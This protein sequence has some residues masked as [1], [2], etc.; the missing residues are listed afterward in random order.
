MIKPNTQEIR[1]EQDTISN[2]VREKQNT[3]WDY[4]PKDEN[5]NYCIHWHIS[6]I[7]NK[8]TYFEADFRWELKWII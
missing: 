1:L 6:S 7:E 2:L 4:K 8:L 3:T 5:N